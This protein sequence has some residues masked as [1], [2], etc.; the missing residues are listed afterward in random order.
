MIT[1]YKDLEVY[2]KS[3]LMALKIHQITQGYPSYE[4]YEIGAQIRRVAMSVPLN[5][6]EGYGKKESLAEFKRF[7]KMSAGS[8]NEM[9]VLIEMSKDLSYIDKETYQELINE[10]QLLGKKINVLIEKWR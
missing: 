6:A 4:R 9:E 10:Y 2:Q 3:Y 1:S 8:C 5:I 7:L